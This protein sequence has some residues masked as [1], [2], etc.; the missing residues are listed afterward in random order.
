MTLATSSA[1]PSMWYNN[2]YN[3]SLGCICSVVTTYGQQQPNLHKSKRLHLHLQVQNLI[4]LFSYVPEV[5][6]FGSLQSWIRSIHAPF[7]SQ[8]VRYL[9]D[10]NETITE[11]LDILVQPETEKQ[12]LE[13]MTNG[14]RTNPSQTASFTTNTSSTNNI[15]RPPSPMRHQPPPWWHN[16]AQQSEQ[17]YLPRTCGTYNIQPTQETWP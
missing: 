4:L 12:A 10:Q 11:R 8:C 15:Q 6:K 9:I 3:I 2:H 5:E 1:C 13:I 17:D 16:Q 7:W 14:A